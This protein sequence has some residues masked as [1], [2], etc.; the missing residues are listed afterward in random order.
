VKLLTTGPFEEDYA[1]LPKTIKA[2]SNHKLE[3][4]VQNPRHPSLRSKKM[5]DP[6]DIW[7]GRIT[8]SYRFTFQ[9]RAGVCILRR[10][11]TQDIL[12]TP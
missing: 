6:R 9:M 10:I 11:G 3:L 5:E 8:R 12:K 1:A 2:L 7:E 4:F